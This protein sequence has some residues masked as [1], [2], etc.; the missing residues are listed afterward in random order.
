[1]IKKILKVIIPIIL[2]LIFIFYFKPYPQKINL[3]EISKLSITIS[4][5]YGS[6]ELQNEQKEE[7]Y[8]IISDLK[9]IWNP[10]F[11]IP[12]K[13]YSHDMVSILSSVGVII[14]AFP[15][16]D[17]FNNKTPYAFVSKWKD[18]N[19]IIINDKPLLDFLKKYLKKSN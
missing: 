6:V 13:F 3:P 14:T 12:E 2:L 4:S 9:I 16:G 18:V 8:N 10:F 19:R 15:E 11:A 1:M 5:N 17:S 7:L